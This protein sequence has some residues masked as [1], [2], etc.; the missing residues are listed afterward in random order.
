MS[1]H[2]KARSELI[3][4]MM[5]TDGWGIVLE[6]IV[7]MMN[8]NKDRLLRVDPTNIGEVTRIQERY[9]TLERFINIINDITKEV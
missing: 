1:K 2:G 6:E 7:I 5:E 4:G 3:R 8:D 9:K